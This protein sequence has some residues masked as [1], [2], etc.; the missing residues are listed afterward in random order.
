MD[1]EDPKIGVLKACRDLGVATVAYSPLGRGFLTGRYRSPDDFEPGDF[2]TYAPRFSKENFAKN[3]ELVDEL[4][5]L[6][7]KKDCT[8]AQLVL[9]FLMAQGED[10]IPIPGTSRYKNYDEN[11]ASLKVEVSEEENREIR[12]AIE[13]ATVEGGR[14]PEAFAT[15]L[16]ADTVPLE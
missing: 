15:S 1:I 16:F 7:K 4:A 13:K 8:S 9:A 12:R 2:R 14:Y 5:R 10:I 3:L 6:G 11:M